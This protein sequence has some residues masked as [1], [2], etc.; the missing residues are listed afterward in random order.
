MV[1]VW[2]QAQVPYCFAGLPSMLVNGKTPCLPKNKT[3][4][5]TELLF[6]ITE[7][8]TWILHAHL[9]TQ[10]GMKTSLVEREKWVENR[11]RSVRLRKDRLQLAASCMKPRRHGLLN[12]LHL[13]VQGHVTGCEVVKKLAII[14]ISTLV[15]KELKIKHIMYPWSATLNDQFSL[16][17]VLWNRKEYPLGTEYKYTMIFV[18]RG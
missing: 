9:Y 10:D 17:R 13:S 16:H 8:L 1:S 2:K 6:V 15:E 3:K 5:K 14:K 12:C 7:Y 4:T 11:K 18:P